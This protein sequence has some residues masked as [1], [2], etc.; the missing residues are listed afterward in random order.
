MDGAIIRLSQPK[1]GTLCLS[2]TNPAQD[3]AFFLGF[4]VFSTEMLSA[5][6]QKVW[7]MF[8]ADLIHITQMRF[9]IDTPPPGGVR[10][11]GYTIHNSECSASANCLWTFALPNPITVSGTTTVSFADFTSMMDHPFDARG[12]HALDF[13]VGPGAFDFCVHD[14]QFLD[15]NGVEVSLP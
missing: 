10:V 6:Y 15:A 13:D 3:T 2:G 4:T 1:S 14:F 9:A 8:D 5:D 11:S 12:F 7:K